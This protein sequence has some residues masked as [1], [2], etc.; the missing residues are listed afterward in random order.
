MNLI[1]LAYSIFFITIFVLVAVTFFIAHFHKQKLQ[2]MKSIQN[3]RKRK[4]KH[5]K[6]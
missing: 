3:E 6:K 1:I 4:K 2:N 5:E